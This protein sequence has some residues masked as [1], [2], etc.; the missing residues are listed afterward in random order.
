MK[1]LKTLKDFYIQTNTIKNTQSNL[2]SLDELRKEAIKYIKQQ[3]PPNSN[4]IEM[5][6]H[7]KNCLERKNPS[8]CFDIGTTKSISL[9]L[10][11][12]RTCGKILTKINKAQIQNNWIQYFFNISE[13]ELGRKRK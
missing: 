6:W 1:E 11:K 12:C 5:Y 2:V 4:K 9:I 3:Q 7:C 13:K 8:S 10:I